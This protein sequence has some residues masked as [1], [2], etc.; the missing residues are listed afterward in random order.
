[1]PFQI[2]KYLHAKISRCQHILLYKLVPLFICLSIYLFTF[3]LLKGLG[4]QGQ[5]YAQSASQ[6]GD[7][8]IMVSI[9]GYVLDLS[10]YIA[11]YASITLTSNGNV[12]ASTVADSQGNFSFSS[13]RVAKGFTTF[14]LDAIDFKR[15]GES[16][17]CFTIPPVTG[18]YSKSQ[19]FLPPTLGVFRTSINVGDKALVFGYGMP[20]AS[21]SIKLDNKVICEKNADEGGYYECNFAIQKE[22]SHEVYADSK[23]N[24]KASEPQL[25]RVLIKGIGL[26][27]IA[28]PTPAIGK[29]ITN[30]L[31]G[32]PGLLIALFLLFLLII[33]LIV[34]LR[35]ANPAWLPHVFVPDPK[36]SL[37]HAFDSLFRERKLHHWWMEGVGY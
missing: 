29:N 15:L 4:F 22:G 8:N 6:S 12:F 36:Q 9:N 10:G 2:F 31:F 14:C 25:K 24:S 21:I 37:R 17:A 7:V 13:V 19:I 33:L 27:K 3:S 1:M 26:L 5:V 35:K 28:N 16:E 34:W 11:P 23:L 30:I 32:L 20:G 18:P